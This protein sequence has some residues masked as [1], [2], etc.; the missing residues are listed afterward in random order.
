MQTIKYSFFVSG[1]LLIFVMLR[2]PVK[3]PTV[4]N[5]AIEFAIT[6]MAII[7]LFLGIFGR[8]FLARLSNT[9][10]AN[11][12]TAPIQRWMTAN[13]FSLACIDA[14]MLFGLV[15]H[16]LRG[17]PALVELLFGAAMVSL[18]FWSPGAQPSTDDLQT[19]IG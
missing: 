5:P 2:I 15:L 18:L 1:L 10:P 19:S 17:R 11:A 9:N 6:A 14:C 7:N 4:A 3:S 8:P 16:F 12:K 13:I